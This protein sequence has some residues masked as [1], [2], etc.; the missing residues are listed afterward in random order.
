MNSDHN[1]VA[2]RVQVR[3]KKI[4]K[5]K[6]QRKWDVDKLRTNEEAFR[7]SVEEHV[8]CEPVAGVKERWKRLKETVVKSAVTHIGYKNGRVA[9]KPWITSEVMNKMRE[10]R[11]CKNT[12]TPYG[13]KK[14]RQLNN[15]LRRVTERAKEKW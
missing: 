10:R 6:R 1:L 4:K 5:G 9:K 12:N 15:E 14:Y 13:K 2:R 11:K 3:L 7:K 8:K